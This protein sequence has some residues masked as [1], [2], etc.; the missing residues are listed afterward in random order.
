MGISENMQWVSI[1]P[2]II[3]I[4]VIFWKKEVI[5]AL[6]VTIFISEFLVL[7]TTGG[8]SIISILP[9]S[10]IQT[11]ERS[12]EVVGNAGNARILAFA[13]LIGVLM[14]FMQTSGGIGA[15]VKLLIDKKIITNRKRAGLVT[16]V[17]G[18]LIFVSTYV[19]SITT[20]ILSRGIFDKFGMSRARLAY[21]IDST[22]API[23]LILLFNSFGA[24]LLG[25][26]ENYSFEQSAISILMGT[27]VYNFYAFIA[28]VIVY[29]TAFSDTV[30][31]PM[32]KSEETLAKKDDEQ[33]TDIISTKARYMIIPVI[34]LVFSVFAVLY[35]TGNGEITRG[36]G[37]KAVLY[38]VSISALILYLMMIS[39][40]KKKHTD[41]VKEAF[42]GISN[43]LPLFFI[44]LLSI[45]LGSSLKELGTG[46]FVA[47]IIG[48]Y[49]PIY[50]IVPFFFLAGGIISFTTG[51]SF[52]AFA[53]L[54]PMAVPLVQS[55]GIPPSF[56]MA[57]II[58]GGTFGD[59]SSPISDTSVIASLSAGCDHLEHVKTQLP[60]T[61]VG[62]VL[63][64]FLYLVV[65]FI[66]L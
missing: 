11:L 32:K 29:Y 23:C 17:L 6:V 34:I 47:S 31:G 33:N 51:S 20:G 7:M 35:W 9:L 16:V 46:P 60:Y 56:I 27:V 66:Q 50:F 10:L 39:G 62:G 36:S 14:S 65:G 54:I 44:I 21:M 57:A 38:A 2:P 64:F 28:L 45:A 48:D 37:S 43:I 5:G 3:A 30:Y 26:L 52:G 4:L 22:A 25:L 61:I 13:L 24:Y 55:L 42:T 59:H 19:S 40:L 58:G 41:L 18:S 53:I 15:T 8:A 49:L 63:A 12:I 1:I